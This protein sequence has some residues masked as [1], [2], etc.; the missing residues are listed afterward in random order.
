MSTTAERFAVIT[1]KATNADEYRTHFKT[2]GHRFD[3]CPAIHPDSHR[4]PTKTL[5]EHLE[6]NEYFDGEV[7]FD[8]PFRCHVCHD[9]CR[10]GTCRSILD[11]CSKHS[12]QYQRWFGRAAN[13]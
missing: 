13:E 10:G 1:F 12:A 7:V 3:G 9:L 4:L 11:Q 2:C 6:D 8:D 5:L